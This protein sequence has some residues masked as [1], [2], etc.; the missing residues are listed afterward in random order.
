MYQR[1]MSLI[2]LLLTLVIVAITAQIAS[3]A[4]NA[5]IEQQRRQV[6]AEQLASSLRNA[7]AEAGDRSRS[8]DL[9]PARQSRKSG[10]ASEA[11]DPE[12]P[13]CSG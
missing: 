5:L 11:E 13:E 12:W 1:G 7:R 3:P 6:I 9:A 10:R 4:Y 8:E 2:Q